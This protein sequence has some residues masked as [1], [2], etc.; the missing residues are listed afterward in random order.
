VLIEHKLGDIKVMDFSRTLEF[1]DTGYVN[2]INKIKEVKE[3]VSDRVSITERQRRRNEFNATK[4]PLIIDSIRISGLSRGQKQYVTKLLGKKEKL[5][6]VGDIRKE[7]FEMVA[8]DKIQHIYPELEYKESTNHFTLYLQIKPAERF[9]VQFGG[10]VSSTT[11]NA[12]F[13]GL[14]YKY[15]GAQAVELGGNV[16]FGRFYS[17]AMAKTRIDFPS[18][19]QIFFEGGFIYN[20]KNYF[21]SSSYFL[22]DITPAYLVDNESFFYLDLGMPITQNGRVLGGGALARTKYNYYQDNSFTRLDTTDITYFDFYD[23][24]LMFEL[25]SLNYKQYPY[26]GARLLIS[27]TYVNGMEK[28][29]PGSTSLDSEE[30]E[31]RHQWVQF[32]VL[33]DN[34]FKRLGLVTFGFYGEALFSNQPLFNN[35]TS[36]LMASPTFDPIPESKVLFLPNYRAHSYLAGGLKIIIKPHKRID[37]RI[38]GY[39]FQPYE[40]IVQNSDQSVSY[41]APFSDRSVIGTGAFVWHSPLGPLSLGVD[42]YD[43]ANEQ[44]TFFFNVGYI[45]FNRSA[46]E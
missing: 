9:Q 35:Y 10:N 39:L 4:P 40:Q 7:Y 44:F 17:S 2:T 14:K 11:A 24:R 23:A 38:E 19:P 5:F 41:G 6:T 13:L 34:Y 25:N 28:N 8:D 29:I 46:I 12:A 33:Y 42:Y 37:F 32:R 36:T 3:L 20:S 15:L 45:I 27:A 30:I 16:Y 1:V 31:R 22:E 21:R 18:R 43:R 26:R